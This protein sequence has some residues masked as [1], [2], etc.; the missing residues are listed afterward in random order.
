MPSRG[1]VQRCGSA[2][3][4]TVSS[5]NP[6]V[7]CYSSKNYV[8]SQLASSL[9]LT[10]YDLCSWLTW[11]RG[12]VVPLRTARHSTHWWQPAWEQN[13]FRIL[14]RTKF[15]V[16]FGQLMFCSGVLSIKEEC[17]TANFLVTRKYALK[18]MLPALP[19]GPRI[20]ECM[21]DQTISHGTT[22]K[23]GYFWCRSL[24]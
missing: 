18:F 16:A 10:G 20:K 21:C 8:G 22:T 13:C 11:C 3:N 7:S 12:T 6:V 9:L 23:T 1:C 24:V 4:T 17:F 19:I 15:V 5:V 14:V 2:S